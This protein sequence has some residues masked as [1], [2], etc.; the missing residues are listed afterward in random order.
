MNPTYD[1]FP[2]AVAR[3]RDGLPTLA[4]DGKLAA[5]EAARDE[6][7]AR[8]GRSFAPENLAA[9]TADEYHAFLRFDTNQHWSAINRYSTRTTRDMDALRRALATLLDEGRPLAERYDEATGGMVEG[10]GRAVSTPILHV[11]YPE[12]YGVWN[13][14]SEAGLRALGLYPAFGRGATAGQ[15]YAAVNA[16]LVGLAAELGVHL[17]TLDTLWEWLG[18]QESLAAPFNAIFADRAQ[19]EWAFDLFAETVRRLGGGPEDE[20]FALTLP[21]GQA[22]MR[23]NMGNWAVLDIAERGTKLQLTALVKPME[24]QFHFKNLSVFSD[25]AEPYALFAIPPTDPRAWPDELRVIYQ[26]SMAGVGKVFERWQR[27]NLRQFHVALLWEA[28]FEVDKRTGLL[29]QGLKEKTFEQRYY[30]ITLPADLRDDGGDGRGGYN[31]WADCLRQGVA[32]VN[33]D[34][35]PQ[36]PQVA[37]FTGLR[38]GDRLVAFLRNKTIGGLGTVTTPY[39]EQVAEERPNEQDFFRGGMWLRVGVDWQ[40][41]EISVDALPREVANLFLY[42]TLQELTAAQFATVEQAMNT[43]TPPPPPGPTIARE[44]Q[45]F[46]ADA[47]AF[48]TEL[49]ANNN[50]EWMNEHEDRWRSSVR[51]PMRALFTDLGPVLKAKFD[52]YLVPDELAIESK[53]GKTLATIKKRWP[54]D[55]G[56]YHTYYW[57][58]FYRVGLTKQA[59]AQLHITIHPERIRLGF[60]M[61]ENA[62]DAPFR[63]RIQED[64]GPLYNLLRDLNLLNDFRFERIYPDGRREAV[65]IDSAAELRE[66]IATDDYNLLQ[67]FSPDETVR[68]GPTLADRVFDA[69]RRVFPI[70]L[71]AVLSDPA[72]AVERYLAA[73]FPTDDLEVEEI[74]PPPVPYTFAD[75]TAATHLTDEAAEELHDMLLEKRQVIFYGPPGTG[76]TYVAQALARLMTGLA[77]PPAE[78][79][80]IVQFHPAYG[81]EEFIEGIRPESVERSDGH[82]AISY[83]ARPGVFVEFCRAAAQIGAPCVFIVDEIN[84]GNIPRIFGEL[85]LLL[86]YRGLEVR[87]PY[88]GKPFR[89]PPNVYLIGTMNTADRSIALVDFALR[90]RFHFAHFTADAGLFD[91]WLARQEAPLPYLGALYR[92]LAEEAIEDANFA[93]GPSAF[94]RPGLDEV[95]LRRVWQRSVM[96][97]LEEYYLDQPAK[98][99]RWQ[100]DGE[101]LRGLRGDGHERG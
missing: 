96:P 37:K 56:P 1:P 13:G 35:N 55:A 67:Q 10:L 78:R 62:K 28:L 7:I 46:S 43:T 21:Y 16:V 26:Q 60:Y 100:W 58:A 87:L 57:G 19:A 52:P 59:D 75:F 88:S 6:V 73:E 64:P 34:D 99:Q 33:F 81:Y 32:A 63:Q 15:Q 27:T 50:T 44:F 91:R 70:Y 84:R 9:L 72:P 51:E 65:R 66:W 93:I 89:I 61:G 14:K 18:R 30:R 83:P 5:I 24:Q 82:Q 29:T 95:G 22:R 48:L 12:R 2:T 49:R 3:L 97:Y 42:K 77:E 20:R 8:F 86:E 68:L 92:R 47:F 38:P 17:W 11:V 98:A 45:G 101:L 36:D 69:F 54:G 41:N 39:E 4:Q 74:E 80:A 90:R 71:W 85:M 94:M 25:T 23:L 31:F 40:P 76:K 79:L 53:F